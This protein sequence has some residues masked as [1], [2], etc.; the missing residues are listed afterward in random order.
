MKQILK[1][2]FKNRSKATQQRLLNIL[3]TSVLK[4]DLTSYFRNLQKEKDN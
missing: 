1:L 4:F 3:P 2:V